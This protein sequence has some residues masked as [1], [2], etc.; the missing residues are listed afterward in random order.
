MAEFVRRFPATIELAAAAMLFA[1]VFGI[2][3]GY[4]AA[5]RFGTW[6]DNVSV[7]GSLLGVAIPVFFLGFIL[8]YIFAVQ[9]GWFPTVGRQDPRIDAE[10]PTNFYVLDGIVTGNWP[11]FVDAIQH[12]VLPAI[13]LGDDPAGHHHPH[14]PRLGARRA[15]RGLRPDG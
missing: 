14:H 12:L 7:A 1:V 2:P 6:I 9:L 3:L 11:A 8:K 13:A 5:R 10:H 15:E 4:Y